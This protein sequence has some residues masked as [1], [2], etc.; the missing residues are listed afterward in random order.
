MIVL[1]TSA[2]VA[3]VVGEPAARDLFHRASLALAVVLPAH[4]LL[5]T[6]IVLAARFPPAMLATLDAV[7]AKLGVTIRPFTAAHLAAARE[8]FL[9]Y[10]K[11]RHPAGLNFGDCM[12]YGVAK[13]EGLP[14]LFV[15]EDFA[16]TDV[17]VA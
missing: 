3:M 8:A 14:L 2:L 17:G 6:H 5:E 9:A 12:S 10:G 4:C 1:E 15:G 16:R 7:V 11:G 13:S